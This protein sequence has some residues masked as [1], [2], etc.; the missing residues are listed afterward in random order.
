MIETR[1]TWGAALLL[2]LSLFACPQAGADIYRYV[3]KNG[4]WHFT[5]I[6]TDARYRLFMRTGRRTWSEYITE[7]KGIIAQASSRFGVDRALIMAV[8]KAE[9]GFNSKAVSSKG[10][11]G[12]MQ[13]MPPTAVAMDVANPFN[14]EENIYG[15]TRYLSLMLKRFNNNKTLALAAYNA[16]PER[17][18]SY[19]GVPPFAE[20]KAFV[21]KVLKYYRS[22]NSGAA[23]PRS[24]VKV[25]IKPTI[26]Q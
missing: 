14:P 4:V 7:Y 26:T 23:P 15:G 16:G 9:S 22:Y 25:L 3:D 20:T 21:K 17:V 19:R 13:L 2:A 8:I 24:S 10:A 11:Q 18:E 12:L 6:K 1:V 5:N